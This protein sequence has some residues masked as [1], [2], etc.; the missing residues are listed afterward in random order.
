M[1]RGNCSFTAKAM[2]I[3]DRGAAGV[4]IIN[5]EA[6]TFRMPHDNTALREGEEV[7]IPVAVVMLSKTAGDQVR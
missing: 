2:N 3:A 1:R 7:D 4:L 5:S 6:G